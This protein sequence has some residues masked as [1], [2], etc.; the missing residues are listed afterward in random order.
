MKSFY[1]LI[2][3]WEV[4]CLP[5]KWLAE[6]KEKKENNKYTFMGKCSV[7]EEFSRKCP[8]SWWQFQFSDTF[9]YCVFHKL[10]T[11]DVHSFMFMQ[12]IKSET[13]SIHIRFIELEIYSNL[14]VLRS[15]PHPNFCIIHSNG[16]CN[17]FQNMSI[18]VPLP[19]CIYEQFFFSVLFHIT[20]LQSWQLDL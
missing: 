10:K 8:C 14:L 11:P 12:N 13:E 7:L 19:S 9:I 16:E 18:L 20:F 15:F 1:L 6:K 5:E 3:F 2:Y 17:H 4:F